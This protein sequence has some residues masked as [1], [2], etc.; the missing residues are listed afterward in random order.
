[1]SRELTAEEVQQE[2]VVAMGPELGNVFFELR[3]E[4]IILHWKWEEFVALFGT[5]PERIE[6]LSK[7]AKSF[8]RVVQDTFWEGV[9]LGIA[10]LTDP[11]NTGKKDN[12]TLLR[13]RGLVAMRIQP[14]VERLI[15]DCLTEA[16]FARNWR[17]RRIAHSDLTLALKDQSARPLASANRLSV[18]EALAAFVRLL[19]AVEVHYTKGETMYELHPLGNAGSLLY[20]LRGG[21][22]AKTDRIKRLKSGDFGPDDFG[23][24]KQI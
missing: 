10:R 12:L 22:K 13:L 19:N 1:M 8:F 17:N 2:Y 4:C 20:V 18:Q 9:L 24:P 23:P 5:K 6:L 14:E 7:A 3:N 11:A 21:V 16:E 15:T